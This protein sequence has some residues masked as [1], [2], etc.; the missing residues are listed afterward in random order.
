MAAAHG[1]FIEAV[2]LAVGP[3]EAPLPVAGGKEAPRAVVHV[4]R[5]CPGRSARAKFLPA[6]GVAVR[7]R[8]GA[9]IPLEEVIEAPVLL[10]DDDD[11]SYF[12][13]R[14]PGLILSGACHR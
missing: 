11:V 13:A 4:P 7:L 3:G 14:A 1:L 10:H 6:A 5:V 2:H 12:P 9:G 8:V